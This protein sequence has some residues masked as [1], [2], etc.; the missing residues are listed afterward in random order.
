MENAENFKAKGNDSF[1]AGKYQDA[2]EHFTKAIQLDTENSTGQK[3]V[4]HSNRSACYFQLGDA[5][6]AL[7]DSEEC[8]R[9][10]PT[11]ARGYERKGKALL[12]LGRN[13]EAKDVFKKGLD[14][15]PANAELQNGLKEAESFLA[16][17]GAIDMA[18]LTTY[19]RQNTRGMMLL[20][21]RSF[22]L[23]NA[24]IYL[25]PFVGRGLQAGCYR[26][27]LF[28]S[29]AIFVTQL[30]WTHGMPKF[31]M[32]YASVLLK[33][34]NMQRLFLCLLLFIHRPSILALSSILLTEILLAGWEMAA[35]LM[36]CA[37]ALA[38]QSAPAV[39]KA[40]A[41]ICNDLMWNQKSLAEKWKV[42]SPRFAQ[43]SALAEVVNGLMLLLEL[44]T[45]KRNLLGLMMYWQYLQMRYMIEKANQGTPGQL[46]AAFG[47][48]DARITKF[49]QHRMCPSL[50]G[51]LY[52][53]VKGF[54]ENQTK[55][56]EPGQS[57]RP[58][59]T[60]M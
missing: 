40:M 10:K 18:K 27:F 26:R 15:E 42:A 34:T 8:V 48:V 44:L 2:I 22:M 17:P 41:A 4:F 30:Y 47:M 23:A 54:L 36:Y 1:K 7:E 53:K 24:V 25:L 43:L 37:P 13:K 5:K 16:G 38:R 55:L 52:A 57:R 14:H 3:H 50:I 45:P 33:D 59:C 21:L 58:R 6:K 46:M 35:I 29:I 60:I 12:K 39:N 11:W 56:P 51:T 19:V 20:A 32:Q 28:T 49:T 31:N 9:L